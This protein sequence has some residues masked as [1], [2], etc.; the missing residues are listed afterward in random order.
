[1]IEL[2]FK[3]FIANRDVFV[4]TP[5]FT[6]E[7]SFVFLSLLAEKEYELA[8]DYLAIIDYTLDYNASLRVF[9]KAGW[10]KVVENGVDM[11]NKWYEFQPAQTKTKAKISEWIDEFLKLFDEAN[12]RTSYPVTADSA[13]CLKKM[14]KFVQYHKYD[15]ETILAATKRY[16]QD[17]S[18]QNYQ[19]TQPVL[20]F[21]QH[22]AKGS[23]LAIYCKAVKDGETNSNTNYKFE[24]DN[25]C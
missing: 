14:S 21:I 17:M 10:L 13:D 4:T 23:R 7:I 12:K 1:M 5:P 15:K 2:N 19:Y 22:P 8:K 11:R 9:E 16:M 24:Q 20:A 25:V 3:K 6:P 18:K